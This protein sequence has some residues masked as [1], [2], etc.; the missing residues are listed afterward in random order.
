MLVEVLKD[1]LNKEYLCSRAKAED[2]LDKLQGDR[3]RM[4]EHQQEVINAET[5]LSAENLERGARALLKAAKTKKLKESGKYRKRW[6]EE[7]ISR[8]S[9]IAK[10][11]W[12]SEEESGVIE[13]TYCEDG[14]TIKEI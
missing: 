4:Q 14:R 10:A 8:L 3:H 13:V 2:I 7:S 9:R 6:S 12:E 11:P 5:Y 1:R